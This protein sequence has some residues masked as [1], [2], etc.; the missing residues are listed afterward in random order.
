M[1][2]W[3]GGLFGQRDGL[4]YIEVLH[5]TKGLNTLL[6]DGYLTVQMRAN[7]DKMDLDP[8]TKTLELGDA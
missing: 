5:L 6:Q 4:M 3:V 2:R 1:L 8:F 7:Y